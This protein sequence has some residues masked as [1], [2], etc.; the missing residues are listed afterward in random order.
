[1]ELVEV[2]DRPSGHSNVVLW[3]LGSFGFLL[4]WDASGLDL[5][6]AR[7]MAG[8]HGFALREHWALAGALHQGGRQIAWLL[9]LWLLAG[10][11]W[12][13]GVLR[14]L[15]RAA[16]VRWLA[17]TLLSLLL[18]SGLKYSS[19]TSCP[20]DLA[21]FGGGGSYLSHWAWGRADGGSGHCFPA[22]HASAA[23]AFVGGFFV[24]RQVSRRRAAQCLAAALGA[25]AVLGLAQQLRGAHFMSHTLWTAWFCWAIAWTVH[26]A[27]GLSSY[28]P[29]GTSQP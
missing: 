23:F 18:I 27:V 2:G 19:Q 3:T 4:A 25:G 5:V 7:L 16:R 11:W 22:G 6:L 8:S 21:E 20:W 26:T 13:T 29:P 12:P 15:S 9:G 17:S 14:Q 28:L 24:L 10:V 1:M